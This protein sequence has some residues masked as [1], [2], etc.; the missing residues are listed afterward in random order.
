MSRLQVAVT[1]A[2]GL[3]GSNLIDFLTGQGHSVVAVCRSRQAGDKPFAKDWNDKGVR[4]AEAD[5]N[6]LKSLIAAIEGVDVVVHAAAVVDPF[7]SR[8]LIFKTNVVGTRN[9]IAAAIT[10]S[11]KQFILV[12]SLS[13][14]S[15]RKD[16]FDTL[17]DAPY[18]P[19]G[20]AYADSKIAAE[21]AVRAAIQNEGLPAT[22]VRPG[23]IYGPREKAWLPRLINSIATGKAVLVDGGTKETNVIYVENLNRAIG[24]CLGQGVAIGQIYNLTDGPGITK[25]QLF[26][27]ISTGLNLPPVRRVMPGALVRTFCECVSGVAPFLSVERQRQLARYSKAAFRLVGQNQGFSIKKAER[28]LG[29]VD[30]IPFAHGMAQTLVYV[31][32]EKSNSTAEPSPKVAAG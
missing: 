8:E 10:N 14:I 3:V 15:G 29:Y 13:V 23:F 4:L 9:A 7:G 6:D 20:E 32:A 24:A 27:A 22:I 28:E 19:C 21:E 2:G 25:K 18:Q 16:Q 30:R 17:E 11:V 26:D 12:S 1:G 31:S 5:V